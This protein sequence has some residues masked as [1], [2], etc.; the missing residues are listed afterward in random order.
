PYTGLDVAFRYR[1]EFV[2]GCSCKQAEYVP[3]TP[4]F[5]KRAEGPVPRPPS[6]PKR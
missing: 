1:K 4:V 6:E 3:S 2:N 5:K